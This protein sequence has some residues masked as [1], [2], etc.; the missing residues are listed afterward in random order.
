MLQKQ[1]FIAAIAF[2]FGVGAV[3][4]QNNVGI[5]T[6]T[7]NANA[8]LEMQSTSQGVLVPRMTT[9]QRNAIA[10]PT[11]GLLVYDIDVNCFFFYESTAASWTSL[12]SAGGVGPQ[13]PAGPA[14]PTGA[15]G[16]TG[17]AGP[18]GA[19]GAAGPQ[20]P[21]G[22]TGPAGPAGA[23][24]PAGPQGPAGTNGIDGAPGAT[25]PAGPQGPIGAT[26]P[27]GPAGTNGVDGAPGA[28]G[29]AG[30]Q[31]PIG[32]TGPQGPAGPAGTNGVDGAPGATGPA[33]PQGPIGA[34]GPQGPAGPAGPTGATGA[35][36]A[37]GPQGPSGVVATYYVS[38]TGYITNPATLT[39][40]PGCSQTISLTAGQKVMIHAVV[41]GNITS[42]TVGQWADVRACIFVNGGF[43]PTGAYSQMYWDNTSGHT[44]TGG[45]ILPLSTMYTVPTTGSYTFG[46]YGLKYAGSGTAQ[47]GGNAAV[48]S[49]A[50]E[51]TIVVFN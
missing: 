9:V 44:T 22:L 12:C 51:M 1:N 29:P 10:A 5:G 35:T 3:Y 7:P 30:P 38:S 20:G 45:G 2:V 39:L 46:L 24:G 13:G 8:I 27:Q 43:L 17:P 15:T 28:T 21:I 34:T 19:T 42:L 41:G 47:M 25:G 36:G 14:G 18:A 16:A 37:T 33:G 11:E 23:A 32:A 31:G 6:T 40:I 50:G 49:N 48:N 26:G 4:A